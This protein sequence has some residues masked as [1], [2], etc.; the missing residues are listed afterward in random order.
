MKNSKFKIQNL[1]FIILPLLML[2]LMVIGCQKVDK[3]VR[4]GTGPMAIVIDVDQAPESHIANTTADGKPLI[5]PYSTI[6]V[7][8][9]M[10]K[11]SLKGLDFWKANHP[12]LV[13]GT[14]KPAL[15]ADKDESCLDCHNEQTSCNNCHS[16]V[17]VKLVSAQ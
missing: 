16:Y 14:V 12:N 13:T 1:K 11:S 7:V 2:V 15:L 10:F 17:G 3:P 5:N 4:N 8:G 9:Q 6:P